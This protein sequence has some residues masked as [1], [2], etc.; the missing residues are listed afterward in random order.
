MPKSRDT[1]QE[2]FFLSQSRLPLQ[3]AAG[4]LAL[5][6][7]EGSLRVMVGLPGKRPSAPEVKRNDYT[8]EEIE[9]LKLA[10]VY[11]TDESR[12]KLGPFEEAGVKVT[13][14]PRALAVYWSFREQAGDEP[15]LV[16]STGRDRT[17]CSL[18]VGGEVVAERADEKE[19]SLRGIWNSNLALAD[20]DP[21]RRVFERKLK[22][23]GAGFEEK[24]SEGF[25]EA[26]RTGKA[27]EVDGF[28]ISSPI[29]MD[30]S[31]GAFRT[32]VAQ[33]VAAS[34]TRDLRVRMVILSDW[35]AAHCNLRELLG[36]EFT[37]LRDAPRAAF[38]LAARG[39]MRYALAQHVV[40]PKVEPRP[41]DTDAAAAA[42]AHPTPPQVVGGARGADGASKSE[43]VRAAKP[44][45]PAAVAEAE[46]LPRRE[47]PARAVVAVVPGPEPAAS[48]PATPTPDDA[49]PARREPQPSNSMWRVLML[50][51]LL[52]VVG[53]FLWAM[54]PNSAQTGNKK[55]P[56]PTPTATPTAEN[57]AQPGA[58]DG[59]VHIAGGDFTM[60]RDD[61]E[62]IERPAH[63]ITVDPFLLDAYEVTCEEYAGFIKDTGWRSPPRWQGASYPQGEARYPVAGV[64]WDDANEFIRWRSQRDGVTYRLPT[65]EEWEFAA[66]GAQG[67]LYPWGDIWREGVA[68][69]GG[70]SHNGPVNVGSFKDGATPE[71]VYDLIGNVWEWTSSELKPY[72]GG[73][74]PE[75]LPGDYRVM[76]GGSWNT[77]ENL[78]AT[79]RGYWYVRGDHD[80]SKTGFRCARDAPQ[81]APQH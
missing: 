76:R 18:V 45:G 25:R 34:P 4:L 36:A 79:Y 38:H 5:D 52:L 33:T 61:G 77:R 67:R 26:L 65:E 15:C 59:M 48:P 56:T 70:A 39:L 78:T 50:V 72:P 44:E 46:V 19:L 30:G 31:L 10:A 60:G 17:R 8:P 22:D 16:I 54:S 21:T 12:E 6:A 7:W 63:K 53:I 66:R 37:V 27:A 80:Y 81:D 35:A 75:V 62:L 49:P 42:I 23:G 28:P 71:G 58:D 24:V 47:P 13:T 11:A 14:L 57:K 29:Y 20:N 2:S 32:L 3:A 41:A 40:A 68:N 64:T 43:G 73:S 74:L 1:N 9:R 51:P 55:T 69:I